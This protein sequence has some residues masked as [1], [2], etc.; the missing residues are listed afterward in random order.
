[1]VKI[2]ELAKRYFIYIYIGLY[3]FALGNALVARSIMG[4]TPVSNWAYTMSRHTV[5]FYGTYSFLIHLAMIAYIMYGHGLRKEW[6]NIAL[7][8]P[9]SF[10]GI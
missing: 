6:Y 10:W 3:V 9:F 1:M 7:Q 5:L 8:I 4:V 2:K